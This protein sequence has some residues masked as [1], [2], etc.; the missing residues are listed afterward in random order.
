MSTPRMMIAITD[1]RLV[2]Y[3]SDETVDDRFIRDFVGGPFTTVD[4]ESAHPDLRVVG[5]AQAG[6]PESVGANVRV[7]G[8]GVVRGPLLIVGLDEKD[9]VRS[10]TY[11]EWTA[12]ALEESG[13]EVPALRVTSISTA[14]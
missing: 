8:E 12:Y 13:A 14:G 2:G 4:I 7:P 5:Y 6:P 11:E 1:R 3:D 9:A 10:M